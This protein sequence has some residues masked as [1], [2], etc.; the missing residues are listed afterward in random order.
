MEMGVQETVLGDLPS[1]V[2]RPDPKER[3]IRSRCATHAPSLG[4]AI[5]PAL[6]RAQSWLLQMAPGRKRVWQALRDTE[7]QA[8]RGR[9][10]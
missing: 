6:P 1:S 7:R 3:R 10:V 5:V 2:S 4:T 8:S 9:E